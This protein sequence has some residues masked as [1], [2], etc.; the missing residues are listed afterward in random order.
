MLKKKTIHFSEETHKYLDESGNAIPS[1]SIIIGTGKHFSHIPPDRQA[2]IMARGSKLHQDVDYFISTGDTLGLPLLEKFAKKFT[3]LTN[4]FGKVVANEKPMAAEYMGY[5][6]AGKPD[7]VCE[8]GVIEVKSSLGSSE[9]IYGIQL[10]GYG[11]LCEANEVID[12]KATQNYA[13]IYKHNDDWEYRILS[14]EY[15]GVTQREAFIASLLKHYADK[16][17]NLYN[18]YF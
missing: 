1:V 3:E 18:N 13:I 9:R 8:G 14:K 16:V 2:D 5:A 11:M 6:F 4:D 10:G 17:L 7:I 15:G 12:A